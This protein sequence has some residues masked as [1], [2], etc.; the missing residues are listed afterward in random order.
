M[1]KIG[2]VLSFFG[3]RATLG[4]LTRCLGVSGLNFRDAMGC[5]GGSDQA[6]HPDALDISSVSRPKRD[7]VGSIRVDMGNPG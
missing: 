2:E 3:L 7:E 5:L 6:L 4:R 1:E